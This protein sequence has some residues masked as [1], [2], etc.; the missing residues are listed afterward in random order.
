MYSNWRNAAR[1]EGS[2]TIHKHRS[3]DRE[4]GEKGEKIQKSIT[5]SICKLA[6]GKYVCKDYKQEA[7]RRGSG[8]KSSKLSVTTGAAAM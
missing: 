8:S 2:P 4:K 5:R 6:L 3:Q 7:E 1:A